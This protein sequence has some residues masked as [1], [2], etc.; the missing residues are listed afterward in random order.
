V[1]TNLGL[2]GQ[3]RFVQMFNYE[4]L[5]PRDSSK[6]DNRFSCLLVS[7]EAKSFAAGKSKI[8]KLSY[9]QPWKSHLGS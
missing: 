8:A 1:E 2:E 5:W 4:L 6:S 3:S 7:S 9:T